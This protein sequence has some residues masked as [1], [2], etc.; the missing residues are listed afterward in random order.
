MPRGTPGKEMNL[1]HVALVALAASIPHLSYG[2]ENTAP[3][4]KDTEVDLSLKYGL[5]RRDGISFE[6][7]RASLGIDDFLIEVGFRREIEERGENDTLSVAGLSMKGERQF[8]TYQVNFIFGYAPL[9]ISMDYLELTSF[10]QVMG[11]IQMN[12]NVLNVK[13]ENIPGDP[14]FEFPLGAGMRLEAAHPIAYWTTFPFLKNLE[15]GAG[16]FGEYLVDQ[17]EITEPQSDLYWG[18]Y[19]LVRIGRKLW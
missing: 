3:A 7:R 1:R 10:G 19:G 8:R 12:K 14:Q 18:G 4:K 13:G 9:K 5:S 15:L 2:E 16:F 17:V 11:G 6:E